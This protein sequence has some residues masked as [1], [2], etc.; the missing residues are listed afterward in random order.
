M[1]AL[2]WLMPIGKAIPAA[3]QRLRLLALAAGVIF[4]LS[5]IAPPALPE[6]PSR[7]PSRQRR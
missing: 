3:W 5:P 1:L 6:R 4:A 2:D 7:C